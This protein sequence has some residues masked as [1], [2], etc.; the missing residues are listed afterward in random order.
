MICGF[1]SF[2]I[3]IFF[4]YYHLPI[5]LVGIALSVCVRVCLFWLCKFIVV[6]YKLCDAVEEI[7]EQVFRKI[8]C[9]AHGKCVSQ[10][11]LYGIA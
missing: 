1:F 2:S 9:D 4:C 5:W 6:H 10:L 3:F 7:K 8:A 11:N